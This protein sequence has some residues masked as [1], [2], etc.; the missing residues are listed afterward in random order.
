MINDAAS[1]LVQSWTGFAAAQR[2]A[3]HVFAGADLTGALGG[4]GIMINASVD[5]RGKGQRHGER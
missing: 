4:Y 2:M 5:E 1:Y 3:S